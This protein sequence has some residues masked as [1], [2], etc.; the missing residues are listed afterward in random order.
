MVTSLTDLAH[1][2]TL[3]WPSDKQEHRPLIQQD[4]TER[5][6]VERLTTPMG[7]DVRSGRS[8]N[9]L[10]R[11]NRTEIL[12]TLLVTSEQLRDRIGDH[13]RSSLKLGTA[14]TVKLPH[15]LTWDHSRVILFLG[16]CAKM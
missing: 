4:A 1:A 10:A 3:L 13:K 12:T 15:M 11:V 7:R 6:R 9:C 2:E 16:V 8:S 5:V 14:T